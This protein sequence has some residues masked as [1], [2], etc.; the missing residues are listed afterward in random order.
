MYISA[1]LRTSFATNEN[2]NV[3]ISMNKYSTTYY[4]IAVNFEELGDKAN[5]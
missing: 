5:Y 1:K 2:Q 4:I 3:E